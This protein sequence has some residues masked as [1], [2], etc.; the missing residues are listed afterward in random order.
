M[1]K[2]LSKFHK[3]C[4]GEV[5]A[6]P[7]ESFYALGADAT[8]PRAIRQLFLV[9][10]RARGNPIALIAADLRQ[11]RKFFYLSAEELRLAKKYWPGALTMLLKPKR[12]IAVSAL[13]GLTTPSPLLPR[14]RGQAKVGVRVPAHAGAR[15]LAK[16]AGVP[17]TATSANISSQ[18]PT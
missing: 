4:R 12:Q 7:T 5:I 9:K 17:L 3:L 13:L 15:R 11:V 16:N 1:S 6:Y 8:N 10:H 2:R 14:R 18:P